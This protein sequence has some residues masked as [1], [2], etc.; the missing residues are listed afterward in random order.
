[1]NGIGHKEHTIG[2][3]LRKH[4]ACLHDKTTLGKYFIAILKI[5]FTFAVPN[6]FGEVVEWSITAVLKTV[7]L[8]G[9]GGSNPSLSARKVA[10][11]ARMR[12]FYFISDRKPGI[13]V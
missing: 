10:A 13:M 2:T 12:L 6:G 8:K 3:N 9:S 7:E 5:L 1:M 11:S 4:K